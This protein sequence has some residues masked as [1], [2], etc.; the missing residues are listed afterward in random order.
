[1]GKRIYKKG[2]CCIMFLTLV[3]FAF[4]ISVLVFI[5]ELGH[6][7]AARSTGMRVEKFSVGFPPRFLSFTSMPGGWDFK[8]FFYKVVDKKFVWAPIFEM[9]I[10]SKSKKGSGTEYCLALLPLGGYVKVSGILDESMDPNSTGADY[11]YQSK[12]TWQKLWFTSAGVIFNF[13]LSFIIFI[14]LMNYAGVHKN[15]IENIVDRF[16]SDSINSIEINN[17]QLKDD[18]NFYLGVKYRSK[19]NDPINGKIKTNN[20]KGIL[21]F[22][23]LIG[24]EVDKVKVELPFKVKKIDIIQEGIDVTLLADSVSLEIRSLKSPSLLSQRTKMYQDLHIANIHHDSLNLSKSPI[25]NKLL[26]NDRIISINKT[27]I[28]YYRDMKP[29]IEQRGNVL[30]INITVARFSDTL[31]FSNIQPIEFKEY[32]QYGENIK[33]GKLGFS[34]SIEQVSFLES[35][36]LSSIQLFESIAGTAIG[37]FELIT[38]QVSAKGASGPIGIAKMSGEEASAGF[39]NLLQLMAMLSISL[40]VINILPFPGLDGGHA[41]IA[42]IEKIKGSKISAKTL[43]R[44]QQFGMWVLLSLFVLIFLKDLKII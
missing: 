10:N 25:Y 4:V 12:K 37:I 15:K 16:Y 24:D 13:I 14:I 39:L 6:Y 21:S 27:P 44:V 2:D 33:S 26:P 31:S 1:M 30:P 18:E 42:I 41:L 22:K 29:L 35:I 43:V 9:F 19:E 5:H 8:I 11:E 36:Y 40:G 7:L 3:S 34:P 28:K 23:N 38:N 20:T 32:N 17:K